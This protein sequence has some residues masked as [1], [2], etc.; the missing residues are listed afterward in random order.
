MANVSVEI[1]QT[2]LNNLNALLNRM[3]ERDANRVLSRAIN[4]TLGVRAGGMRKV[5]AEEIQRTHNLPKSFIYK[6]EGSKKDRTFKISRATVSS[7]TG[8]ISTRGVNVP[9]VYYSNQRGVRKRYDKKIL[10]TVFKA[11]GPK[12]FRHAFIPPLESG[13]RG[14]FVRKNPGAKGKAGRKIKQLFGSR[15]PDVL[16]NPD[17]MSKVERRGAKDL[18][19]YLRHEIDY[20]VRYRR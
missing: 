9:L 14:L 6:Q 3:G 19:R 18:D 7:P 16:S 10:V 1:N 20:F 13:H 4:K 8:T 15:I 17:V 11:K 5:I 2:Q 12:R